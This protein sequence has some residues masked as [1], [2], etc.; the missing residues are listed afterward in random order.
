MQAN[1]DTYG[2]VIT[3]MLTPFEPGGQ[4]DLDQAAEIARDLCHRGSRGIMVAGTTGESPT[5]SDQEKLELCAAVRRA[6]G[7]KGFVWLGT[8]SNNTAASVALTRQAA[9]AGAQGV[10]AVV[11]YYSRPPQAGLLRHF[12]AIAAATDLPLMIYNIP[13]RTGCN[14]APGTLAEL[15]ATAGNVTAIKEASRDLEQCSEI[16]RLL[17]RPFCLYSGDDSL[18]L[19]TLAVGGDGVVSVASHLVP[20]RI[21]GLIAAFFAGEHE[22]AAAEH[23]AL[24]PLISALFVTTNPIPLKAAMRLLGH[25]VGGLRLPLCE[26]TPAEEG[27]VARAL[28]DLGLLPK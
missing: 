23:R 27:K 13:G 7:G 26:A 14:L 21:A 11:P 2:R 15:V 9:A 3:A 17:P 22:R 25:A 1:P 12:Q 28:G 18:L 20:E 10:M 8:G 5:L 24:Q 16:R 4:V 19:P 6:V